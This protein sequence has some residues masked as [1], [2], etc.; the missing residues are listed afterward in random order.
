MRGVAR[1]VF[2]ALNELEPIGVVAVLQR[3]VT[4]AD[5]ER[6]VCRV[7]V[8]ALREVARS[9][10]VSAAI[11]EELEVDELDDEQLADAID[12]HLAKA[13]VERLSMR[14][15]TVAVTLELLRDAG[16]LADPQE[17]VSSS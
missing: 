1:L 17:W 6:T 14:E 11:L 7:F 2:D 16:A 5:V 3:E 10:S 12:L 9:P 15:L 4:V 8:E 13:A